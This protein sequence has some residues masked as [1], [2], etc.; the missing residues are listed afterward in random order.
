[1]GAAENDLLLFVAG[2][3]KMVNQSLAN[4]RLH[5]G[6]KLGLIDSNVYQFL[7]ILDFRSWSMTRQK[8]GLR[9]FTIL[10]PL[11]KMKIFPN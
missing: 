7:W 9:L 5:L 2:P 11:P 8:N 3:P 6:E 1:M 4:L 10:S